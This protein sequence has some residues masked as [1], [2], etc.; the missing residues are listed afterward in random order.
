MWRFNKKTE[1]V[2]TTI[3]R[4]RVKAPYATDSAYDIMLSR[5]QLSE[6][7][8]RVIK[9]TGKPMEKMV[10]IEKLIAEVVTQ[11]KSLECSCTEMQSPRTEIENAGRQIQTVTYIFFKSYPIFYLNK[12]RKTKLTTMSPL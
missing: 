5:Q 1:P 4:K 12:Q 10:D 2:R 11:L 9:E 6:Q 7:I 3:R 8:D